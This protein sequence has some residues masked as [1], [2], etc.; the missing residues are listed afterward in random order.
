MK[1]IKKFEFFGEDYEKEY[2]GDY[3]IGDYVLLDLD[4]IYQNNI[5]EEQPK[6]NKG[7]LI[8]DGTDYHNF[9]VKLQDD[10][11]FAINEDEIERK[12]TPEEIKIFKMEKITG[13]YNI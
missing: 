4:A 12:M 2:S 8:S 1:H 3:K 7:I 11:E 6:Y 5:H 13:K 9:Y 10:T